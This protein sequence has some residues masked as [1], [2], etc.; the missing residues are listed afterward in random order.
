MDE[1]NAQPTPQ[2]LTD[3][4]FKVTRKGYD[5]G[6]VDAFLERLSGAVAQ[7]QDRLRQSNASEESAER[8]AADAERAQSSMQARITDL[9]AGTAGAA[10]STSPEV[11]AE[12]AASVLAMAQRTADAVVNDA[13]TSAAKLVSDAESEASNIVRDAQATAEASIGDLDARRRNLQAD[14]VALEAF[15]AEQ[16]AS[17]SADVSR[18]LA[19]LDDPRALRVAPL[20]DGDGT[21]TE[22]IDSDEQLDEPV[23][24]SSDFPTMATPAVESTLVA[25]DDLVETTPDVT[26]GAATGAKLFDA[27]ADDDEDAQLFGVTDDDADEAMRKFFDADFEDDDRFGR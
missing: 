22:A 3:I 11:E 2:L 16:R 15:L 20:R 4:Q 21:V 24:P 26:T 8:R 13:R 27:D 10:S 17:L 1:T 5:P 19:V 7:M 18:I 12:Q 14:V 25:R 23:V 6:E 9:E